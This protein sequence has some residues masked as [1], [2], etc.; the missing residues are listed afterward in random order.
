MADLEAI[1]AN[2]TDEVR[3]G[4]QRKCC[5]V[6]RGGIN[7]RLAQGE[8]QLR[9]VSYLVYLSARGLKEDRRPHAAVDIPQGSLSVRVKRPGVGV[10]S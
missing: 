3:L 4:F 6:H 9:Q 5:R 2:P 8:S 10:H 1:R 7:I